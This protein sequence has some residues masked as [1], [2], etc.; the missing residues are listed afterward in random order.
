MK[1]IN[2]SGVSVADVAFSAGSLRVSTANYAAAHP[3][4][5]TAHAGGAA[6]AATA[7]VAITPMRKRHAAT[8][9]DASVNRGST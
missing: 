1:N 3:V 4:P 6:H 7:A 8:A 5:A 9:T 2:A